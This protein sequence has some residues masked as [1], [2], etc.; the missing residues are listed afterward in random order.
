MTEIKSV[1]FVCLRIWYNNYH[2]RKKPTWKFIA[3]DLGKKK[4]VSQVIKRI[5]IYQ[6]HW[7]ME[8]VLKAHS[9]WNVLAYE[10]EKNAAEKK[11][12]R[13]EN[14]VFIEI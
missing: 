12:E 3:I 8:F 14:P 6:I 9:T 1:T 11:W 4:N 7:F 13:D 5:S 10:I 2:R